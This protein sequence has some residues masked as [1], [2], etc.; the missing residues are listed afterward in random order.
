MERRSWFSLTSRAKGGGSFW[1]SPWVEGVEKV[2]KL[3]VGRLALLVA[4]Q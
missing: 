1:N 3:G 4:K 2:G